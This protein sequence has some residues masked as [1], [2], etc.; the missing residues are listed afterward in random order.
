[1]L[2]R[3]TRKT[4]GNTK[5]HPARL[6]ECQMRWARLG[7]RG[8]EFAIVD[9]FAYPPASTWFDLRG[10]VGE[11]LLRVRLVEQHRHDRLPP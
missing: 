10:R 5:A 3:A 6:S 2:N 8:G 7:G 1:M 4:A 11:R 9:T